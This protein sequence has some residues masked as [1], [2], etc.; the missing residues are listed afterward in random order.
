MTGTSPATLLMYMLM[1][2][3]LIRLHLLIEAHGM[4]A[5]TMVVVFSEF[6][7]TTILSALRCACRQGIIMI[8]HFGT[9][10]KSARC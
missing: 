2:P 4:S 1:I 7:T 9:L 8:K 3:R 5:L 10:L 6:A